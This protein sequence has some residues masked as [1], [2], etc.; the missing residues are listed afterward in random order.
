MFR[1][2]VGGGCPLRRRRRG[3]CRNDS[4]MLFNI[5]EQD[6]HH[7][8]TPPA[9]THP[10][11]TRSHRHPQHT[12][13][14]RAGLQLFGDL[15]GR[16]GLRPLRG[17]RGRPPQLLP[18]LLWLVLVSEGCV[19]GGARARAGADCRG[20]CMPAYPAAVTHRS[21]T[22]VHQRLPP[23]THTCTTPPTNTQ[24]IQLCRVRRSLR[25][26]P[27]VLPERLH[28][29]RD[30]DSGPARRPV[31]VSRARVCSSPGSGLARNP[32]CCP[33][34]LCRDTY[35]T[36]IYA[37]CYL[38]TECCGGAPCISGICGGR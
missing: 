26:R 33:T 32:S 11:I 24:L 15:R 23:H 4:H 2:W 36:P 14:P 1:R 21:A 22:Y 35:C 10:H 20:R 29:L 38:D 16:R 7:P 19:L 28:I 34:A 25:V 27:P 17:V 37:T 9:P 12:C 6:Q 5:E 18:L 8:P 3:R 13:A 31:L 30:P